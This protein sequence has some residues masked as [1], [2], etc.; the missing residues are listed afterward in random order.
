MEDGQEEDAEEIGAFDSKTD[1]ESKPGLR[2]LQC[3]YKHR[4]FLYTWTMEDSRT[5][6]QPGPLIARAIP[7][8]E[9]TSFFSPKCPR[10]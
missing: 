4:H 5:P 6:H 3:Q 9:A 7:V 1:S 8:A 10:N 2:V